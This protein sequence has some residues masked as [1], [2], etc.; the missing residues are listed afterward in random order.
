MEACYLTLTTI[1][2]IVKTDPDPQTYLCTP[3]EIVL[4]LSQ[5]DWTSI[6]KHLEILSAEKFITIKHLD[7]IAISITPAGITKAKSLKNN[8]ISNN[9]SFKEDS[10]GF[11]P[12]Q[13]KL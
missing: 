12:I 2:E 11:T 1:Y 9:F 4:R 7:K 6:Q 13:P 10:K 3:H 8:F 5:G